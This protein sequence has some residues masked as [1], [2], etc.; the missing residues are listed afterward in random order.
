MR[1]SIREL[2]TRDDGQV[3][4]E[5]L[6][7]LRNC[8]NVF[9]EL[10]GYNDFARRYECDIAP[11]K[12]WW[13][14]QFA[15][16][17]A[18]IVV[19]GLTST[20]V[21]DE[22][23]D[24]GQMVVGQLQVQ[25]DDRDDAAY[26]TLCHH[27]PDWFG[28]HERTK[29]FLTN[30]AK[31]QLYGHRHFLNYQL[32]DRSL[33]VQAG[34]LQP[35]RGPDWEPCYNAIQLS[36][37]GRGAERKLRVGVAARRWDWRETKFDAVWGPHGAIR[38][39]DIAFPAREQANQASTA[40]QV[41][42]S[43]A[44]YQR[45]VHAPAKG[46][47][48]PASC[49]ARVLNREG[50]PVGAGV[51]CAEGLV[52]T[53][54][55][56]I[57]A[58]LG[59]RDVIEPPAEHVMLDLPLAVQAPAEPLRARVELWRPLVH[60]EEQDV[61]VL[62]LLEGAPQLGLITLPN[63]I[64]DA[65]PWGKEY[66]AVG[67]DGLTGN[68][69]WT[70]G[71]ALSLEGARY[72]RLITKESSSAGVLYSGTPAWLPDES[73]VVGMLVSTANPS[74]GR[75][76]TVIPASVIAQIIAGLAGSRTR[77]AGH[78]E[79]TTTSAS[80]VFDT[81]FCIA[82]IRGDMDWATWI[83]SQLE[84]EGYSVRA[85]PLD[86]PDGVRADVQEIFRT[87]E[88]TLV[89]VSPQLRASSRWEKLAALFSAEPAGAR[90]RWLPVVVETTNLG[91][92]RSPLVW[93]ELA[94]ADEDIAR[95]RLLQA[96]A[97]LVAGAPEKS[98]DT[99]R[100]SQ[101]RAFPGGSGTSFPSP[102][103]QLWAG[104]NTLE[105][106]LWLSARQRG[107]LLRALEGAT[108]DVAEWLDLPRE[109]VRANLFGRGNDGRLGIVPGMTCNMMEARELTVWMPV[110]EGCSGRCFQTG[111]PM[112]ARWDAPAKFGEH[113]LRDLDQRAKVHPSL[114]WI[115]SL[116][117]AP[118]ASVEPIWSFNVDGIHE[119]RPKDDLQRTL[120]RL[121]PWTLPILQFARLGLAA[122]RS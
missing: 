97:R 90:T 84:A 108:E 65:N 4:E 114:R 64:I 38:N 29:A 1:K 83:R 67:F 23:D 121:I 66:R 36:L 68:P 60:A 69:T 77:T 78:V 3:D 6:R 52:V 16:D 21:S 75:P 73:G 94:G 118:E 71:I 63:M 89:I 102:S 79:S 43:V 80:E 34:A 13:E 14:R 112:L 111:Q 62:R 31:I 106:A 120:S 72:F 20:L 50:R 85:Q 113:D 74:T 28:D 56:V 93:L 41:D 103:V 98:G 49:V 70:T 26:L 107:D 48:A 24:R 11:A 53:C 19:R 18:A 35:D 110:G 37:I 122:R 10:K 91:T 54:A 8:T 105:L 40:A 92:L 5:L 87:A 115:I 58:A 27:P 9:A 119:T 46:R 76:P 42:A 117:I 22:N 57:L 17:D 96:A 61:A 45:H 44:S 30:R 59:P 39:F 25:L 47:T 51:L 116:P 12:H 88:R 33:I 15:L 101:S 81:H 2:L 95:R 86:G 32:T 82:H 55:R 104:D 109:F 7:W 99:R 100:A